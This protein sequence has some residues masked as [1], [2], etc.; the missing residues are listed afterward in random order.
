MRRVTYVR[1]KRNI[2]RVVCGLALLASSVPASAEATQAAPGQVAR[3]AGAVDA[4][5]DDQH[6]HAG[7][8]E[9]GAGAAQRGC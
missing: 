1:V 3:D 7:R 5:A 4:A 8:R 9:R 6:I 2:A